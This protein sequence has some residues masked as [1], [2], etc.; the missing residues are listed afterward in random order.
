ME[1]VKA[2]ATQ[3]EIC[4]VMRDVFGV[5]HPDSLTSGV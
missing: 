5:Y 1:A 4:D 2:Y 3:G